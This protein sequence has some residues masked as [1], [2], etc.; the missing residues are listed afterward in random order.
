MIFPNLE[1]LNWGP[2]IFQLIDP[3][4]NFQIVHLKHLLS[5]NNLINTLSLIVLQRTILLFCIVS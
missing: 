4:M 2:Q 5:E 3:L 1:N